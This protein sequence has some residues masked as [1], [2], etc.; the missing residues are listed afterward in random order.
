MKAKATV[1]AVLTIGWFAYA[2]FASPGAT[3]AFSGAP[4]L[5]SP[6]GPTI[7]AMAV[8]SLIWPILLIPV[9]V[10]LATIT[11]WLARRDDQ[12]APIVTTPQEAPGDAPTTEIDAAPSPMSRLTPASI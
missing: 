2:G 11:V 1:L 10:A 5:I 9:I 3:E 7:W 6:D 8:G 4:D 12:P